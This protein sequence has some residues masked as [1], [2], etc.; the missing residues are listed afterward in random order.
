MKKQVV[1]AWNVNQSAITMD[2][3]DEEGDDGQNKVCEEEE[4]DEDLWMNT[5]ENA[6]EKF[7]HNELKDAHWLYDTPGIVKHDCV[8]N[9]LTE[10]EVQLVLPT[11]AIIPRTFIL[12][13]GSTLFLAGLG[14]IDYLEGSNSI[15]FT[16]VSSNALPVH[17]TTM[18][19]AD[20]IY[21]KHLGGP[22]LK[23][24][25]GNNERLA[26]FPALVGT[27]LELTG[28]GLKEAIGD[29]KLSSIGWVAV[30]ARLGDVVR[31]RAYVPLGT[32]CL[33]RSPP[34]LPHIVTVRGARM[35]RSPSYSTKRLPSV[36]EHVKEEDL[37]NRRRKAPM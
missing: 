12:S 33:L 14:R 6:P 28:A 22:L 29:V 34:L 26:R 3:I 2:D 30:T 13:P 32:S 10:E 7:T 25:M 16:V 11:R 9:M 27:D 23:L 24:P 36:V 5:L 19:K 8:L 15:W 31:L 21:K 20:G 35:R 17:V 1:I 37:I 18:E 4:S